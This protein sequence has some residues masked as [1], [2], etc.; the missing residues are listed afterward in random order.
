MRAVATLLITL[1]LAAPAAGQFATPAA[2]EQQLLQAQVGGVIDLGTFSLGAIGTLNAL[3][4]RLQDAGGTLLYSDDPETAE[5]TGILYQDTVPAGETRVYLYHVNGTATQKRFS[6]V[7]ENPGATTATVTPTRRSFPTPS[8]NYLQ[9]GREGVRLFYESSTVPPP[10]SIP[11][12]GTAILDPTLDATRVNFNALVGTIHDFT[13]NVPLRVSSVMVDGGADTLAVF[14]TLPFSP[15]DG[16]NRQGSFAAFTRRNAVAYPFDTAGGVKTLRIGDSN[17]DQSDPP[18]VGIDAETGE[19]TTLRGN[20]GVTYEIDVAVSN[21]AG[22][23]LALVLNPRGGV[24]GGYVRVRLGDGP[25][26]GT[27]VPAASL[28]VP[29]TSGGGV[30]AL[31][32]PPAGGTT[33]LRVELIPAG[34]SSL[35]INLH[36]VPFGSLPG[37]PE[38]WT[39]Y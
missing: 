13:S 22:R 14:P 24:Y 38:L 29:V 36:L 19:P 39:L 37:E 6:I 10:L 25:W 20:Y 26:E 8:G 31:I 35:A 21:N 7:L 18:L 16:L 2:W 9:V 30:C 23:R 28:V 32:D 1:A 11:A 12:G 17:V 33:N 34:A 15:N 3:S 27:L 4:N 5:Q